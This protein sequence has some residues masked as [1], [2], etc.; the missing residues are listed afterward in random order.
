MPFVRF[1]RDKRGYEHTYLIH[2]PKKGGPARVLYW[3]RTPPGVKV[4]RPAFDDAVRKSLEAQYPQVEFDWTDILSATMPPV[5]VE[6]WRERRRAEKA[7]KQARQAALRDDQST[8]PSRSSDRR[9]D[10]EGA[11]VDVD[12]DVNGDVDGDGAGGL[13]EGTGLDELDAL[14]AAS[15]ALAGDA[16]PR[17]PAEHEVDAFDDAVPQVVFPSAPGA[18]NA[19]GAGGQGYGPATGASVLEPLGALAGDPSV[20]EAGGPGALG[21]PGKLG[22]PREPGELGEPA[23]S[24][25][26]D[27]AEGAEGAEGDEGADD[28]DGEPAPSTGVSGAGTPADAKAGSARRRR[29]RGGRRRRRGGRP[30]DPAAASGEAVRPSPAAPP[31]EA[32]REPSGSDGSD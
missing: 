2:A 10:V 22:E 25:C 12:V 13:D 27:T 32:P 7:A 16:S 9:G 30:A 31:A 1:S 23:G 15:V 14:Q 11:L 19:P 26:G 18:L 17:P 29:R 3:Y 21:E 5:E 20:S 8:R 6:H 4:G 24:G 28:E